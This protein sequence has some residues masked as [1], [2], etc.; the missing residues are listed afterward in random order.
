[1]LEKRVK[2]INTLLQKLIIELEK[3]IRVDQV[4]LFG[5]YSRGTERDY[6]D[7]DVAVVSPDFE[8]G[9]EKDYLFVGRIALRLNPLLE[10]IPYRSEDF[11]HHTI[12]DFIDE[13]VKTGRMIYQRAA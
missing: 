4:I 12:G 5:S 11:A 2:N 3:D 7:I 10:I 13:I 1:M 9:T 8:G 6:S